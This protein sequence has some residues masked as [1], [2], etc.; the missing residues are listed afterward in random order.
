MLRKSYFPLIVLVGFTL[1]S[2][3]QKLNFALTW[4]PPKI[5]YSDTIHEIYTLYFYSAKYLDDAHLPYFSKKI[6][7]LSDDFEIKAKLHNITYQ[8]LTEKETEILE[9]IDFSFSDEI[10]VNSTYKTIKKEK[11]WYIE[12]LPLRKNP[13][14]NKIEKITSGEIEIIPELVFLEK[15]TKKS[16]QY[17]A[18][19]VLSEN[20][21]HK[22]SV[23]QPGVYCITYSNLVSM[24]IS[25][26][27]INPKNIKIFG[28]GGQMLPELNSEPRAND[29]F[30]NAIYVHG[31]DNGS[32]GTNDYILFYA[33]GPHSW[34]YDSTAQIYHHQ[35]NYYEDKSYYFIAFDKP[36]EGKRINTIDF[37]GETPGKTINT[38]IDR[39][40]HETNTYNLIKSG[41]EWYGELFDLTL[42]YSF[43][44]SFPNIISDSTVKVKVSMAA[45]APGGTNATVN[46]AGNIISMP[47]TGTEGYASDFAKQSVGFCSFNTSSS[48]LNVD[49]TYDKGSYPG[50]KAWLEYI[51][52]NA[53]R[54]LT[55]SSNQLHFRNPRINDALVQYEINSSL[56][57]KIW[58]ITQPLEPKLINGTHESN[59]YK[60]NIDSNA[61]REFIA[62]NGLSYLTP[63]LEGVV[64]NQNL[65]ALNNIDYVI[66]SHSMFFN[67]AKALGEFHK[68]YN[69]LSYIVLTPQKIYNE[70]SS[71]SQDITAIRDFMKMLYDKAE[72]SDEQPKYLL[73]FGRA[74]YDYKNRIANNSNYVPAFQSIESLSPTTS[75]V[76]NDFFGLLD[77]QE[78]YDC[79]GHLDI[80]IGRIP[81]STIEEAKDVVN[82]IIRYHH[83]IYSGSF[84][85]QCDI[86]N[87][88]PSLS[89]WRNVVTFIA[90][91]ED[92]NLHFNQAEG[93][94]N[95][96]NLNYKYLNIDK[97]YIAAYPQISTPGG[98]RA[99][100]VN[101]AINRR[102]EQGGL[103]V[104]YT[105]HGGEVGWAHERILEI[106]DIRSWQNYYNMPLFITA[107][108]EFSRFDDPGRV[109]AGEMILTNPDGGGIALFSTTRLAFSN[110]NENINR[111]VYKIAF[112]KDNFQYHTLGEILS[113]AKTDNNSV[114]FIRN[115]VLLG[116]PAMR[117]AYP[118]HNV[119]TD[120]INNNPVGTN[121]D[122]ISAFSFVT[123][124]GHIAD[125]SG[126]KLENFKGILTPTV[127]DK[128]IKYQTMADNPPANYLATFYLQT[129]SL[130]KGNVSVDNGEF[131]FSFY[132]PKDIAYNFGQGKIS[133]YATDGQ[134]DAKG[135]YNEFII[136]GETEPLDDN[137][138]PEI[139]L[140]MNDTTFVSGSKTDEN[141][142]LLVILYDETGINTI[143]IGIGHD[144]IA[145]LND[146][147]DNIIV[148]NNYFKA[149]L[150][151]YQ[152]GRILYPFRNLEPGYY[153]LYFK[154]WDIM[155]NSS[156]ASIDFIVVESYKVVIDNLM[157]YPNP[158]SIYTEF[159]FK[160]NQSCTPLHV[161]IDIFSVNGL[162]V[163]QL[164]A[165]RE[166]VGYT[167]EP[168]QWNGTN[169]NGATLKSGIYIYKVTV[170]TCEGIKKSETDKLMIIK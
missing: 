93:L 151:S 32:F 132:V 111:S 40:G 87:L 14:T 115:F 108:C 33:Q 86:V 165:V 119:V 66:V 29:L 117:L 16:K 61:Q 97:I 43:P 65:H 92:G 112:E 67:E 101:E 15:K 136:G 167:I 11:H 146:D 34:Y 157:N 18:N 96:L 160:H 69:D 41:K 147:T 104:N 137:I 138:G 154:A 122:T 23:T 60:F 19:S 58:D 51:I 135:Y 77:A 144:I 3:S 49:I 88:V 59:K 166:G 105:G 143:G 121:N 72:N 153:N 131:S 91:D 84:V 150:N 47:F 37:M 103:I 36:G 27:S 130:Y 95:L 22:I 125:G 82:K 7:I 70:F 45:R 79:N 50:A 6:G 38:F 163:A 24:G 127:F 8:P 4:E 126:N 102:V 149:D 133:Y 78:G 124:K 109:A 71:G 140:Y 170:T 168:I 158:F 81:V 159:I 75:Y 155:N 31:E 28:N 162:H 57:L 63:A 89:D 35:L 42:N 76:S 139:R 83:K 52:I 80:G 10:Y 106:S 46:I 110:Y 64:S 128:P 44:F 94:A 48:T 56:P 12:F 1:N 5:I 129:N 120:S 90:D 145:I 55:M 17:S 118:K 99:P 68:Q 116:D 2:F 39:A 13:E 148:L 74:S 141:P 85:D 54:N 113:F 21:W 169:S 20:T 100:L 9:T 134:V 26:G 142:V 30:E 62:F 123:I 152:K 156:D 53:W 73:L 164:N 98:E 161:D 25:P 114:K 107:T